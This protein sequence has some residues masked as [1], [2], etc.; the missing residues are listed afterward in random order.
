MS[1]PPATRKSKKRLVQDDLG[2]DDK[3]GQGDCS[4][5]NDVLDPREA[6]D[7][8]HGCKDS[9]TWQTM[10]HRTG[11]VPRLVAV[12]GV[13]KGTQIPIYRHPADQSPELRPYNTVVDKLREAAEKIVGHPLNHVL[14]QWYRNGEDNISE[15]SDKTLD[16]VRGSKI[17][18]LSLGAQRTMTLRTKKSAV[19]PAM[20][21]GDEAVQRPSQRIPLAHNSIFVLGQETNQ[22]WLHAIRADKRPSAEKTTPE[23]AFDGQRISLTFRQIGTFID[24]K[25][26]TIWG[27]GA[28]Y[29]TEDQA[30]PLLTGAEAE[31]E[32]EAM[33]RA[34]GQENHRSADWDWDQWYG[35][36]FDVINFETKSV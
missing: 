8:F 24:L 27:Q 29:K 2:P 18:N 11:Q 30:Q 5:Y 36:G 13:E 34:F 23:L 31:T 10:F 19:T 1:P 6:E 33:I 9:I 15:H 25:A 28:T 26:T 21:S 3:I 17:V 16:I 22:H 14:I 32:G 4:L 20:E 35:K 7:A 12:Q